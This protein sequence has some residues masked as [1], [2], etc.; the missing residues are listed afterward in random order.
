MGRTQLKYASITVPLPSHWSSSYASIIEGGHHRRGLSQQ[1]RC[2]PTNWPTYNC[3]SPM[4]LKSD[5]RATHES[6]CCSS[7]LPG[8]LP[9]SVLSARA[10]HESRVLSVHLFPAQIVVSIFSPCSMFQTQPGT[11]A[12]TS[13]PKAWARESRKELKKSHK[14]S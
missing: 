6:S 12:K 10:Q 13:C 7:I 8:Q 1:D 2:L 11:R 5:E 4:Y 9:L 3:K 14:A